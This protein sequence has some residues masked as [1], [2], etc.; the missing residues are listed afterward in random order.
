MDLILAPSK[1]NLF[2]EVLSKREDGYHEILSLFSRISLYDLIYIEANRSWR[3]KIEVKFTFQSIPAQH[4]TVYKAIDLFLKAIRTSMTVR[5]TVHKYIPSQSGLGGGST[6]AAGVL[7]W[8]N[9]R[10]GPL[11]W[12]SLYDIGLRVGSDVGFFM[13]DYPYALVSGR[14]EKVSPV[15]LP[16]ARF[17]VFYPPFS[18]STSEVYGALKLTY[19]PLN[20][21]ISNSGGDLSAL[22]FNRLQ[23][24]VEEMFPDYKR[25]LRAFSRELGRK[26]WMTGSGSAFFTLWDES[27]DMARVYRIAKRYN[28]CLWSVSTV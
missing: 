25:M 18:F 13:H 8:L 6:D 3:R 2:L 20:V 5:V 24:V 15:D 12:D 17:L 11:D 10:F 22:C 27:V 14:G 28:C 9:Q 7:K 23:S 4:S 19:Q 26:V 21:N 16:P 1:I